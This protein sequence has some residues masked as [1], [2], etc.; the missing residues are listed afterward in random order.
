MINKSYRWLLG[1]AVLAM[2]MGACKK[3]TNDNG[4][5]APVQQY[6]KDYYGR[7]SFIIALNGSYER[8]DSALKKT[9]LIDTLAAPG[10]F[11]TFL[12]TNNAST[13]V[14]N[15]P[16]NVDVIL[17]SLIVRGDVSLKTMPFGANQRFTTMAG[18]HLYI[19]KYPAGADSAAW[20]VNGIPLNTI[21]I[22]AT[23][24]H[25]NVV[26]TGAIPH[27]EKYASVLAYVQSS[28]DL[29]FF[30]LAL[31]RTGLE[32]LLGDTA[33]TFTLLTPTDAAFKKSTDTSLNTY[34]GLLAAD[35]A[36]LS[37]LIRFHILGDRYF[38]TDFTRKASTDTARLAS[39][40]PDAVVNFY[41]STNWPGGNY[42]IGGVKPPAATAAG[43]FS[44]SYGTYLSD[45][46][47][48]NGVVHEIDNV[49]LP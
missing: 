3:D 43:I 23:N 46:I 28:A 35:T 1:I 31:K 22:S 8:Y 15:F 47:A 45:N 25:I 38:Y 40:L 29:T 33:H 4:S 5:T 6:D 48:A 26:D 30:S 36:K 18:N 24:G 13:W 12:L 2:T 32:K 41:Y 17:K 7:Q 44:P 42:F 39:L 21:D 34:D 10:P 11:T 20:V 14:Y 49:L 27:I 16:N 19:S 9:R 37:R